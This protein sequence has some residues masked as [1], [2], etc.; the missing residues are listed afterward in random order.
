MTN[1]SFLHTDQWHHIYKD[2][3]EAEKL[4]LTSPK[5]ATV[6]CRSAMEMGVNWLYQNDYDLEYPYDRNLSSLVHFRGFRELIKPTM[7]TELNIIRKEG[8]NA[9]H[10]KSITQEQALT[11]LK[12]LFRFLSFIAVYYN[13]EKIEISPF[14]EAHLPDGT[15]EKEALSHLRK[16]QQQIDAQKDQRLQLEVQ[17]AQI[18][19]LQDQLLQSQQQYKERRIQ[20][21]QDT[22]LAPIPVLVSE[23]KT[24]KY[25]ID[26]LLKEA[27]WDNLQQ[28]RD[29]E[30]K[31]HGMPSSTN[32]TGVGYVDYVLWDEKG[33]PLAVVE[34]KSTFKDPE[35]GQHQAK[36]YADCLEQLSTE[37]QRPIIYYSN[38]FKTFIWDDQFYAPREIQGF[39]T[40]DEL[41][42]L[43]QRRKTRLNLRNAAPNVAIAGRPYQIKAIKS[44]AERF[45][46]LQNGKITGNYREALLVMATGSGK[47]R[48]AAAIVDML[49]KNNWVKKVLFLADR[50]ALVTQAK[51]AFKQHLPDL[52]AID[53]TRERE[54]KDARLVFSTY[55]TIMNKIDGVKNADERFYGVGHFDLIIIDEAHRSV[56]QKYKSIFDYFDALMLGLTA[57]PKKY[58]DKNTYELFKIENE[59]PTFAYELD[60]AVAQGHLVPPK[61]ISVPLKFQLD[62]VKYKELSKEEQEEYEIKL[63]DPI[64]GETPEEIGGSNINKWLFNKNTV[65]QVLA[66]LMQEGIKVNGG[67]TIGKTIIFARNHKHAMFIHDVFHEMYPYLGGLFLQV[68]DNYASKAQSL[69]EDFTEVRIDKL[70]QIAVSVDMMDT[71]VDAPKVVN[72]VFF[73][74]VRSAAK[75]WQMIGRGTRLQED[76]F[77]PGQHKKEFL[78]FDYCSNFEFFEEFPDGAE[79]TAAKPLSQQIFEGRL[80]VAELIR[81][82]PNATDEDAQLRIDYLDGL[83]DA[84]KNLD[85]NSFVIRPHRKYVLE[86]SNRT[87]WNMLTISDSTEI[88]T[89]LSSLIPVEEGDHEMARRFDLLILA[90]QINMLSGREIE[91]YATKVYSIAQALEKVTSIPQVHEQLPLLKAVQTQQYWEGVNTAALEHLRAVLRGLVQYL[92]SQTREPVY[93]DFEDVLD[94]RSIK[95]HDVIATYTS[96]QPYKE[97]VEAYI[98]K[99][100]HHLV[101]AKL[102]NNEPITS[103]ELEK[104]EELLFAAEGAESKDKL[105]EHYGKQPLGVFIRS[106]VGLSQDALNKAF[107]TF[108]QRSDLSSQ[109]MQFVE[110][111]IRYMSKNGTVSKRALYKEYPFTRLSDTGLDGIFK[112]DAEQEQ[113]VHI[114]EFISQNALATV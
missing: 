30:F 107:A 31:V 101:I 57:T 97:R 6:L 37:K 73:K 46:E 86:Y 95:V 70:P 99:N 44:V 61:S 40:K 77:G 47:T 66:F 72:L 55:P 42:Y 23:E 49:L 33:Q 106:I 98:R 1:F 111:I 12:Y 26:V 78:I 85:V 5:A 76:L 56:Y 68:I 53:L 64:T 48:T 4:T 96:L 103:K 104:L 24:R 29:L 87:R 65:Q 19:E 75:F 80:K 100:K 35:S 90:I 110:T 45:C 113:I 91:R 108:L 43:I 105:I 114:V 28:G 22:T 2:A 16:L 27:G 63:S 15:A 84:V 21:E 102:K 8:N 109:Q 18:K 74:P 38:G 52:T 39:H 88:L 7:F 71:G 32:P 20:R 14:S 67:D 81:N 25:Y 9:A 34:A 11:T 3:V 69:L 62:G 92:E 54:S 36:L 79:A 13:E 41:K 60:E 82:H 50:N 89:H 59:V 51:N 58:R 83:C 17:A 94:E 112:N 10:G 93:T